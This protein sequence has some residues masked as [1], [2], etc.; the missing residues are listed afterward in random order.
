MERF[1][2]KILRINEDIVCTN[3]KIVKQNDE[4]IKEMR[5]SERNRVNRN[6]N[7]NR[8]AGRAAYY[9]NNARNNEDQVLRAEQRIREVFQINPID[10]NNDDIV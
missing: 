1:I 10:I 3:K 4:L 2:H 5:K 8:N 7:R 9:R 6:V